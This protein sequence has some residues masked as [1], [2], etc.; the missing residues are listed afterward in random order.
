M[1]HSLERSGTIKAGGL[2]VFVLD[3]V[4]RRKLKEK[5]FSVYHTPQSFEYSCIGG[6]V[7]TRGAGQQSTLFGKIE[8]MIIGLTVVTGNG[9]IIRTKPSPARS[10]GPDLNQIFAG[11]E[12]TLGII[13]EVI[14]K[15]N[16]IS[17]TIKYSSYMF[18]DFESGLNAC[19]EIL[20]FSSF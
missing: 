19:K 4:R 16:R 2:I 1:T 14:L 15:I 10:S 3:L 6:W 17:E 18:K 8:D 9:Q 12:G 5:G 11:S 13:T 20:Y 7:A